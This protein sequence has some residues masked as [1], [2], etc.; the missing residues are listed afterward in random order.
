MKRQIKKED[1]ELAIQVNMSP[2]G[3]VEIWE[4]TADIFKK[5]KIPLSKKTLEDLVEEEQITSLLQ[6]LNAAVGSST[7]ICIEGG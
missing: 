6:E 5:Y 2:K 7:A 1:N 3:I 4:V